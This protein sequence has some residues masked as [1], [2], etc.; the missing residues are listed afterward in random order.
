MSTN[1]YFR[2]YRHDDDPTRHIGKRSAAGDYCWDCKRTLCPGGEAMIHYEADPWP[3]TCPSC[4]KSKEEEGWTSAAGRELGFN[5]SPPGPKTGVRSASSF[6]WAMNPKDFW[7]IVR[8]SDL[9]PP[10][11]SACFR[12]FDDGIPIEDEYGRLYSVEEFEAVILECPIQ[13]T[14]EV[15]ERFS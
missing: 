5:S 3:K 12:R 9:T 1:F 4:G 13:E 11:C 8:S 6:C 14:D 15:G 7:G 2:G 10:V